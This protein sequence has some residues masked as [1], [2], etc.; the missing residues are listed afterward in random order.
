MSSKEI[1]EETLKTITKYE[2]MFRENRN[3][4]NADIYFNEWYKTLQNVYNAEGLA[5]SALQK[6]ESV[7]SKYFNYEHILGG[8]TLSLCFDVKMLC[9]YSV[10]LTPER[11]SLDEISSTDGAYIRCF[12]RKNINPLRT[13]N[14]MPIICVPFYF[15]KDTCFIVTDGNHRVAQAQK[16]YH[17]TIEAILVPSILAEKTLQGRFEKALYR[18]SSDFNRLITT[19]LQGNIPSELFIMNRYQ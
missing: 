11:F 7:S 18:M 6:N 9:A 1:L 10:I 17:P 4:S 12:E 14:R 3:A 8:S 13:F 19:S 2:I 5:S 15:I 16:N